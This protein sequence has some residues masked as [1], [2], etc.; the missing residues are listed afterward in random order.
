MLNDTLLFLGGL[1]L[2]LGGGRLL[3]GASVDTARRLSVSPLV[4]GL[5]L[6]AWGTSAP[7]LALNLASAYK[8]RGDLALGN[9]VGANICNLA[10]VLGVCALIRPLA[11]EERLIRVE[12][13]LNA[14]VLIGL[15][16]ICMTGEVTPWKPALMLAVFGGYSVWTIMASLRTSERAAV[17]AASP[18]DGPLMEQPPMS[19]ARIAVF[20]VV[21]LAMLSYGG[22]LASD[23][24]S[25]VALALGVPP[26]VV[27]VTIVSVGT[28]LP[29]MITSV[30][31]VRQGRTDLGM[32][33]AIGSCLFNAGAIF[34]VA[35]LIDAPPSDPTMTVPLLYMAALSV[36]LIPFSRTDQRT[37]SR[38]EGVFLLATYVGFLAYSAWAATR[39]TPSP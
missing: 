13:W 11:V 32:G 1:V 16:V 7:E 28:T 38:Y 6:V 21:G 37:I 31:A 8:D 25:G 26:A 3:V 9:V 19:W 23:G 17:A 20:F 18:G 33:N 2:L 36:V 29:E 12:T 14:A 30:M 27:G 39:A 24:A 5:T 34:G 35:A 15:A 10:L 4:V 22:S